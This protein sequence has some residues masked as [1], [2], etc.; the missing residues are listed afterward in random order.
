MFSK[1]DEDAKKVLINMKKEMTLLKHPY[2]GTEHLL[3]SIL[4]YGN[5][6]LISKLKKEGITYDSFR[7]ELIRI[8]GVGTSSN[9]Y[10]L[11]TPLLRKVLEL[12][13]LNSSDSGKDTVDIYDL[14]LSLFEEA[15]GV[16][17][18][19]LI[20]MDIDID[21]LYDIFNDNK[22]ITNTKL[23]VETFGVN[24][25]EKCKNGDIDPVVGR[26]K[27]ISRLI[28]ILSRRTKNNPILLGEA[29]VGKTAIVGELARRL[30]AGYL[31]KLSNKKIISVSMSS[32]VAG[33]K[34]RGEFEERIE[35]IINELENT[36]EII[37]FIDE[38]HTLVGAGGAEGAIDASNI[39]KP[40]LARGKIKIIGATT[41]SEYKE[42][43]ESDKALSRRFQVINIKEPDEEETISILKKLRPIYEEYH[44]VKISDE[45]IN[46]I[47][48]LSNRYIYDRKMPDKAIDIMDEVC[49]RTRAHVLKSKDIV[50]INEKLIE[51][52]DLKNN[53]ILNNNFNDAFLY[54]KTEMILESKKNK[55][56]LQKIKN[57]YKNITLNDVYKIVEEQSKIPIIKDNMSSFTNLK[58]KLSSKVFGQ[59]T[60]INELVNS[61]KKKKYSSFA[62]DK[63]SSFLFLGPTG[64]GKTLLA[65]EYGD[66]IYGKNVIRIDMSE[67]KEPHSV[68]KMIGSPPGY[69][70]YNDNK[71][72]FELVKDNPYSLIILDEIEKGCK[73]VINLFLQILDEGICKSS[74][75]EEINFRNTT[76]IMTSNLGCSKNNIGFVDKYISEDINDFFGI[77]FVNRIG[78]IIKF[79]KIDKDVCIKLIR[80]K[81]KEIKEIYKSKGISLS[82]SNSLISELVDLCEYKKFG[83]RRVNHFIEQ[84]VETILIDKMLEGETNIKLDKSTYAL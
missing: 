26:E 23:L 7:E 64:V 36:D 82:F 11:Y 19:I 3:L 65:K 53:S 10:F 69:V 31:G 22:K 39:L 27:E 78:N 37:L 67:Y 9:E 73:E 54:K 57:N 71:N 46:E 72:L 18:R 42:F 1:Y 29:G 61:Y 40:A 16:A 56:E 32:L 77:E 35:K 62:S 6:D 43:I 25:N 8:V 80:K 75:G 84:K 70:G 51:I 14:T 83:L 76:I 66:Y 33:T 49:S 12:A 50:S 21:K 5:E 74:K 52:R 2:I 4:K 30:N 68:S 47:V 44:L 17:I 58:S 24:L 55:M 38:I 13:A 15:E 41:T 34:Y 60:A 79:N 59:D 20:S 81:L 45:I 63:P 48:K 28:E